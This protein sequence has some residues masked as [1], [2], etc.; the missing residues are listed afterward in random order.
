MG[1]ISPKLGRGG[2]HPLSASQTRHRVINDDHHHHI[3]ISN[4]LIIDI[5][6]IMPS[7]CGAEIPEE[8]DGKGS[9]K[10]G[11]DLNLVDR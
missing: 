10:N 8:G 3:V 9:K 1:G 2:S 6:T 11:L 7:W 5:I 4:I